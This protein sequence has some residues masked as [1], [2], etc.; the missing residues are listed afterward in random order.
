MS[1]ILTHRLRPDGPEIVVRVVRSAQRKRTIALQLTPHGQVTIRAPAGTRPAKLEEILHAKSAWLEQRLSGGP[2]KIPPPNPPREF[3]AGETFYFLGLQRRLK[4]N[5]AAPAGEVSLEDG[6]FNI[7]IKSGKS[8]TPFAIRERLRE[9][10]T[11]QAEEFLPKRVERW[12]AKLD[13]RVT[14]RV[15]IA[16]QTRRWASCGKGAVL[17]FNWRLLGA[18]VSLIDYVIAHELCHLRHPDHSPE[19][20]RAMKR[21]LPDYRKRERHLATLGAIL[22]F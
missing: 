1:R 19:F 20:W 5:C 3:V 6:F 10:F 22:N 17:R 18:P 11:K 7:S 8:P 9:W 4:L 21:A 12:C 14:P 15:R 2:G 16:D 13:V